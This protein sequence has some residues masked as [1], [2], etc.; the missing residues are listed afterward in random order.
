MAYS[1][2]PDESSISSGS[3]L[4]TKVIHHSIE[5]VTKNPLIYK[6]DYSILITSI[7]LG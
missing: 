2:D 1:E 7:C 5:N 6:I 3:S 4:F